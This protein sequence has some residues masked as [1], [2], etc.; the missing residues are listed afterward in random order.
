MKSGVKAILAVAAAMI[1]GAQA[2]AQVGIEAGYM[3]SMYS[4]KMN[5]ADKASKSDPLN[6]FYAGVNDNIN[7][8]A[9]LSIQPGLY[10]SFGTASKSE[11]ILGFKNTYSETE[12]NLNVPVNVKYT[13]NIIPSV[14]NIS[15][16]VGPTFSLGLASQDKLSI[17]GEF[18]GTAFDGT[19]KYDNYTGK[20]KSDNISEEL[21]NTLN[22][23]MPES[24]MSRFDIMLGGGIGVGLFK[25]LNVKAGYDYGLLNRYKGDMAKNA[26]L[27]RSQFYVALGINF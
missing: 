27:N 10:Y 21:Q 17:S 14:L 20:I 1:F 11:E 23:Y 12:H 8:V 4:S 15:I 2:F 5:D 26:S 25:F 22:G 24:S 6:G 13:F 18:A 19:L 3:N 9:G 16:F 7:I